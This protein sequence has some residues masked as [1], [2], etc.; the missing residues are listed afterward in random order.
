MIDH[1][2]VGWQESYAASEGPVQVVANKSTY[3]H[4]SWASSTLDLAVAQGPLRRGRVQV[5]CDSQRMAEEE[6]EGAGMELSG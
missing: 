6:E 1:N 5:K 4:T 3:L 2:R